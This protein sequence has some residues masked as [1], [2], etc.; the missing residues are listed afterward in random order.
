MKAFQVTNGDLVLSNGS[1]A[2]V[3]GPEKIVQDLGIASATEYGT[4]RF[5]PRYGSVLS[6]YIGQPISDSTN[7]LVKSE[8]TRIINNYRAIQL[9][10]ANG[11][12]TKGL[13][14]PYS[15]DEM[16]QSILNISVQQN[17]DTLGVTVALS[18]QSGKEVAVSSSVSPNSST[19][20]N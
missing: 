12:I 14:A 4:D 18:T 11:Y 17:Y 19:M 3:E 8:M 6:N 20:G 9:S 5:H 16:V 7:M 15:Q 10:N 1:F 13:Q 2:T